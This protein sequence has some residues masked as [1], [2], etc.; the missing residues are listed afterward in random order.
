MTFC[1]YRLAFIR[2]HLYLRNLIVELKSNW[3]EHLLTFLLRTYQRLENIGLNGLFDQKH[4]IFKNFFIVKSRILLIEHGNNEP[5]FILKSIELTL[6][7]GNNFQSTLRTDQ[8]IMQLVRVVYRW[9]HIII[10]LVVLDLIE[11]LFAV[12]RIK[13]VKFSD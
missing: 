1:Q 3:L 9:S 10:L 2:R 8:D 4:L 13:L 12:E 11:W 5:D 7:S 6:N